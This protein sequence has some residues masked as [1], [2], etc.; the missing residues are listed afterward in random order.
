M[1]FDI[2]NHYGV[3]DCNVKNCQISSQDSRPISMTPLYLAFTSSSL[4]IKSDPKKLSNNVHL[5]NG[6]T[7]A[8]SLKLNLHSQ[9]F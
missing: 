5:A 6:S 4:S 9:G 2:F 1:R 7:A 8:Q 3:Y